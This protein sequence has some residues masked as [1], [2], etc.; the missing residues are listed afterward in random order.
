[1]AEVGA[2]LQ[3]AAADAAG[4]E[5]AEKLQVSVA[6]RVW[7]SFVARVGDVTLVAVRG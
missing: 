1:M 2:A 6:W 7:T 5:E 3:L 4:K